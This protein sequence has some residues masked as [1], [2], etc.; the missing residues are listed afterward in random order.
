MPFHY[1]SDTDV[2]M[3]EDVCDDPPPFEPVPPVQPINPPAV[4][5]PQI[6]VDPPPPPR[7]IDPKT[8]LSQDSG[9]APFET[10]FH[11]LQL[12]A[13]PYYNFWEKGEEKSE[14][15]RGSQDLTEIPR[16]IKLAWTAA[17][18]LKDPEAF[19]KR[20][21][22]GQDPGARD[23]F[24]KLSP[25][26]F[27]SHAVVGTVNNGIAWTPPHLQ[28]EN[29]EQNANAIANGHVF[30]G[31]LEAVVEVNTGSVSPPDE[32]TSSLLDEDQYLLHSEISHGIPYSEFNAAL[33]RWKSK[34]YGAQQ[35][36]SN[37]ALSPAAGEQMQNFVAGQFGLTPQ[38]Q[39]VVDLRS[40]NSAT[41]SISFMGFSADSDNRSINNRIFELADQLSSGYMDQTTSEFQRVKIK[42]LH[43]NLD[44]LMDQERLDS[45][46]SPQNAE[47]IVAISP[48]AGNLAVYSAA[49]MQ[50]VPREITLPSFNAPATLKPSE[51]IGYV[52]EKYMQVDGSFKRVDVFYIPGRDYTEYYDC[53]VRYGAVYRYRIRSIF[54]WCRPRGVGV[55][56]KDP[57]VIDAPG[58]GLNSL[59]PN[60]V[61][62]FGSEW[63]SE[64]ASAI[65]IDTV[66]P[67]PPREFQVRTDSKNRQV[68]ITFCLPYNPQQ[69]INKMTLWKKIK[70]QDGYDLTDWIQIQEVN[71]EER[72]GTRHLFVADVV[73]EQDDVTGTKFS[74]TEREIV[75][76][77]VEFAPLNSRFVDNDVGYFGQDNSYR[78][79][80]AA[81]CHTRHGEN[82]SLSDQLG[83]RLNPH[84]SRDGEFPLDFVSC[85]GVNKDFDT[86][87]FSTYPEHRLRSEVIFKPVITTK[88]NEPGTIS[89]SGQTRLAHSPIKGS[90]YIAR[91]ESLDTG[92]HVDIPITLTVKDMAEDNSVEVKQVLVK[93]S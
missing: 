53:R 1:T 39:S 85:A 10:L 23:Q 74:V 72:Q 76:N 45:M 57:T 91:V 12:Q 35:R 89:I 47:A 38:V 41:P 14:H 25:F 9:M 83:A 65:V 70:D 55:F 64:W 68:E 82:S 4:Q 40:V 2:E 78:Y 19:Q 16:F 75:Q 56:G 88:K 87:L 31:I 7:K 42:M 20:K 84:W 66:P 51:Y 37:K 73:H 21:L 80:Y 17:P 15:E 43:T 30:S 13:I 86:G 11:D 46:N 79:V 49:G 27:G 24:T 67:P 28:P 32:P 48:F 6:V 36:L 90:G 29:F 59:A 62:Y 58:A 71:A 81:M 33:W 5:P 93:S 26:G 44:G 54:R 8:I 18:D 92:Q 22:M 52:I 34:T 63:G 50:S 61:S 69:D 3:P 60:D 77:F